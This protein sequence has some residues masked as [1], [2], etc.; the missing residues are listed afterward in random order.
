MQLTDERHRSQGDPKPRVVYLS[1]EPLIP[2]QA[3]HTH[4]HVVAAGLARLGHATRLIAEERSVGDAL[5][6][7]K[8]SRYW[9]LSWRCVRALQ[10]ADVLYVRAHPAAIL[11]ALA[12]RLS[13][14]SVIQEANGKTEDIG[15]SYGLGRIARRFLSILQ[16]WQ[17]RHATAIVTVTPG[18]AAWLRSSAGCRVPVHVVTNGAD[19]QVFH[20]DARPARPLEGRYLMFFGGLVAWHGIGTM[21]AA[22]K[23]RQWPA[24]VRLAIAGQGA[25]LPAIEAAARLDPRILPLG[26]IDQ[27][28][29]AGLVAQAAAVLCPVEGQ[30]GRDIFGVAPLKMFEAM[31][32]G[33]PII[34]A[35][36]PFLATLV[37]RVNCGIVVPVADPEALAAAAADLV[38]D[39]ARAEAM[40]QRG[41]AA[42][43]SHYDWRFRIEDISRIMSL[44]S[45]PTDTTRQRG[46]TP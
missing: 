29:L 3:S 12:G 1:L 32:A 41:R 15:V 34:A 45:A 8:L 40:G 9:R 36:L 23:S 44:H 20:P 37:R 33:R 4:V 38:A 18:L 46:A 7:G 26:Y 25:G 21:L 27:R 42:I 43:E 17:F 11:S 14:K 39:P 35:D 5:G 16:D 30:G 28:E 6:G 10:D 22:V 2:G 24:D 19:G 31:A 13:G